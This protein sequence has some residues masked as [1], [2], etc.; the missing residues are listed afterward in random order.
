MDLTPEQRD[1]RRAHQRRM[2]AAHLLV[3]LEEA[4]SAACMPALDWQITD[5]GLVGRPEPSASPAQ[6]R[7]A[8]QTWAAYLELGTSADAPAELSGP[9]RTQVLRGETRMRTAPD[10]GRVRIVLHAEIDQEES[11]DAP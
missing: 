3:E 8:W 6:R 1:L 5:L 9:G 11:T 10:T 7:A 2:E 4:A